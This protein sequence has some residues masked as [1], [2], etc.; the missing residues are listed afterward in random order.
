MKPPGKKTVE[1]RAIGETLRFFYKGELR[2]MM[3][4]SH[5][6]EGRP[7]LYWR[8]GIGFQKIEY[9]DLAK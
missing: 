1:F 3:Q 8:E 2:G 4:D 7:L 6:P 9:L 5:F